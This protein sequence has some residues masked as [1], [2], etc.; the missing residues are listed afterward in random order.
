MKMV[1]VLV[2]MDSDGLFGH[3]DEAVALAHDHV[4]GELVV[5]V[6]LITFGQHAELFDAAGRLAD[7]PA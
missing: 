7:A 2:Q 6:Q 1:Q 3:V 4:D 5:S